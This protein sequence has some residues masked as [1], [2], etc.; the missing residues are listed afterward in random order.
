MAPIYTKAGDAGETGLFGGGRVFKDHPRVEACGEVDELNAALG[1]ARSLGLAGDL[2]AQVGA[3]QDH[4]FTLGSVLATPPGTAADQHIPHVQPEWT[5]A[6]EGAIDALDREIPPLKNFILPGGHA[7]ASALHLAR[8]ICRRAERR[9]VGL[10]K[11]GDVDAH[12]IAYLNRLSDLL[13]TWA[14]VV[15][16]RAGLPDVAWRAPEA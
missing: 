4:L 16:H 7:A 3:V 13:F 14:R 10:A 8:T 11:H 12:V 1:L 9:V 2:D 6:M 5:A 15:N